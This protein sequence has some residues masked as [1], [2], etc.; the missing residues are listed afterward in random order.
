MKYEDMETLEIGG[1]PVLPI[2]RLIASERLKHQESDG[3]D[4]APWLHWFDGVTWTVRQA[5]PK[6]T[7]DL[8][9]RAVMKVMD[10]KYGLITGCHCGCRGDYEIT[11]LGADIMSRDY[12]GI[13]VSGY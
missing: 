4:G 9:A 5:M 3:S 8:R 7:T 1:V 2:L 6:G 10:K 12:P 13:D 11:E